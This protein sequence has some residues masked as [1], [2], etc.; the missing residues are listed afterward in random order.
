VGLWDRLTGREP[1]MEWDPHTKQMRKARPRPKQRRKRQE[2]PR[3][4]AA[5]AYRSR[6]HRQLQK[7]SL[8]AGATELVPVVGESFRQVEISQAV[9]RHGLEEIQKDVWALLWPDVGNTHD[10]NAVAVAIGDHHVG[11]LSREDAALYRPAANEAMFAGVL[12]TCEGRVRG[13][14]PGQHETTDAGVMLHLP[15][16][17][18]TAQ[19]VRERVAKPG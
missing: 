15:T 3:K 16:P 4:R 13:A 6:N 14:A 5:K 1:Q 2:D 10:R 11:F 12:L 9:G 18:K 19:M 8:K 17:E 7:V